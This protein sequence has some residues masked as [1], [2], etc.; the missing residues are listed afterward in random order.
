MYFFCLFIENTG[1]SINNR[2]NGNDNINDGDNGN[3]VHGDNVDLSALTGIGGVI[4]AVVRRR[5][6]HEHVDDDDDEDDDDD[7][8][9]AVHDID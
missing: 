8:E 7:L 5:H 1:N 6:D 3:T 4:G 2:I 9:Y